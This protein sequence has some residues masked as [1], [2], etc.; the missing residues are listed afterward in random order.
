[1]WMVNVGSI[2]DLK[3]ASFYADVTEST[4]GHQ[5]KEKR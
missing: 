2:S 4:Q 5:D 1:M 3:E